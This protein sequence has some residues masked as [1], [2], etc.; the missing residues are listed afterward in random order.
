MV[1]YGLSRTQYHVY[2]ESDTSLVKELST[3]L[4]SFIADVDT[5][6]LKGYSVDASKEDRV[7]IHIFS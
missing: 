2:S 7:I 3:S 4:F 5:G 1:L 6:L